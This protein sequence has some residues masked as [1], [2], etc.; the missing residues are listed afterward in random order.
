MNIIWA[1]HVVR[2]DEG[3]SAFAVVL[4]VCE[5]WYHSLREEYRLRAFENWIFRGIF[6]P[7]RNKMGSGEGSTMRSFIVCT[8]HLVEF[9]GLSLED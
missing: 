8:I 9:G 6:G 2:M 7:R 3:G 4:Y 5:T 1:G